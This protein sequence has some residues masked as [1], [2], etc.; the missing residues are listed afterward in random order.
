MIENWDY[1]II[2]AS[3]EV[4]ADSYRQQLTLRRS[5]GLLEGFREVMVVADPGGR[6]IGSGGSTIYS[7]Q[8][9]LSRSLGSE[10]GRAHDRSAWLETLRGLRI[11]ILHAGG[12]SRRLPTYGPC[13]K[14]FVPLPGES[15]RPF[16][17]TI[18]DRQLPVYR[19]LPPPLSGR[20]QVVITSGDV[21]LDFDTKAIQ[22]SAEGVTG[23]GCY[24]LPEEARNHG[25]YCSL[26]ESRVDLFLQKP[27]VQEQL[28][29]TA[30]S[31]HGQ[32]IMDI[33]V[34]SLDPGT[35]L[36]L[37]DLCETQRNV[38]G[39][40]VWT[41]LFADVILD[42]G[43]DFYR[44]IGC[45]LGA[46]ATV[47]SHAEVSTKSGSRLSTRDLEAVF[48][49]VSGTPFSVQVLPRCTFQHFGTLGQL[50]SS[51]S[52]LLGKDLGVSHYGK[53][54]SINNAFGEE[55][56]ILG[57]RA[58]VEGSRIGAKLSLSGD[59]VVA[60]LD[61]TEP[62]SLPDHACIDVLPGKS[63]E[64]NPVFFVRCFG[65]EDF[66]RKGY[67]EELRFCGIL[68]KEWL[69]ALSATPEILWED[70]SRVRSLWTARLFPALNSAA[71]FKDFVW[72][73]DPLGATDTQ[74]KEWRETD[75][76]S[77]EEIAELADRDQFHRRRLRIRSEE[78]RDSFQKIFRPDGEF[79]ANE[80]FFLLSGLEADECAA[81]IA[82]ILG[83]AFGQFGSG[84][85]SYG[86]EQ[87]ELSRILHTI[88]TA[89][90]R[91]NRNNPELGQNLNELVS[92]HL[93]DGARVWL[94]SLQIGLRGQPDMGV[95]ATL[96]Q[97]VSFENLSQTIVLG[98]REQGVSPSSVLRSDEIVWGRAPA[99]L[100]L[101]GGWTDTPPYS[102]EHGGCV[103]NAAV[104]LNGQPP[105]QVFARIIKEPVIRVTSIDHGERAVFE[106][107][108]QL[109]NYREATGRFALAKA[110]LVLSGFS[111]ETASWPVEVRTLEEMLLRFGGGIELTTLAA[112]PSGSGL[113]TSSIMG[114]V[115]TAVIN[116]LLGLR[117][118]EREL[119]NRVLQLEQELTTGGGWQD[120]IGGAVGGV[121]LISTEPGLVPDPRIHF[122]TSDLVLPSNRGGQTLLYYTGVRRLAKD[123][124]RSVVGNYL[125]RDRVMMN[126]LRE[127]RSL[128]PRVAE[129]LSQK[130]MG[131]FGALID[132]AWRLNKQIDPGS[133]TD[134]IDEILGRVKPYMLGAKLLGAGGGGFLLI[135]A[136]SAA[137]AQ[138]L[139]TLLTNSPPNERARF[140][141]YEISEE[142]L[143][144]TVC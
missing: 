67:P 14:L 1:L 47:H 70:S 83:T 108:E 21:L 26:D 50:I 22:F 48:R 33:G 111:Q 12:D 100:D 3:S 25:V 121:K 97:N 19:A 31:R 34:M 15:D 135:V 119:F 85:Q 30:V 24:A 103:I 142:G 140:F 73:F 105:I 134:L 42:A 17:M 43:L 39:E 127:L 133:T 36:R 35:V 65:L 61:V 28:E 18:F 62:L 144:V 80:L 130:D 114:G 96:L 7:V 46:S 10:K 101:G 82:E 115:L 102:L 51:G 112:I 87:L 53:C 49:A 78:I 138:S 9:V 41:G 66:P 16:S 88:G 141:D 8:R 38:S 129:A 63:R 93:S 54:I 128:P 79:S 77:H 124:L 81:W 136:K 110:A 126:T 94:E 120:Q 4:Q 23:L 68:L 13:G 5:L 27:S 99:R 98:S 64:G 40:L 76:Y 72:M 125:D 59:N 104:D 89:V 69:D 32:S 57:S 123:I 92:D 71:G 6:R 137:D 109:L 58:W 116:R 86:K 113:G 122:V 143:A 74:I 117:L 84:T 75:R 131:K 56:E 37:L 29:H 60:G 95:W 132:V 118:S 90:L 2:S 52:D 20:G 107:L 11:L 45:A 106:S 91:L 55:G 139:R 44:E